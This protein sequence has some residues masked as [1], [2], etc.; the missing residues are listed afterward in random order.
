MTQS[1]LNLI[2]D[3]LSRLIF[4][5]SL[6]RRACFSSEERRY[7]F[8]ELLSN[9]M[10]QLAEFHRKSITLPSLFLN[11]TMKITTN[12]AGGWTFRTPSQSE[13]SYDTV[14]SQFFKTVNKAESEFK[15]KIISMFR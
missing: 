11:Y 7:Y 6:T 9:I 5:K 15:S 13:L 2:F 12:I 4:L 3:K 10:I 14:I 1:P 8:I